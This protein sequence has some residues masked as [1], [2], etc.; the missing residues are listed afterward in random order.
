MTLPEQIEPHQDFVR[1]AARH[2]GIVPT[3]HRA[4][5]DIVLHRKRRERPHQLEGAADAAAA[6]LVGRKAVDAFAGEGNRSSVGR[7]GPGNDVEQR[8]LARSVRADHRKDR[9]L[10]DAKAHVV[11]REQPTKALANSINREKRRHDRRPFT[12]SLAASHGHTPP[13]SAITTASKQSP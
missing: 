4:D 10:G 12:P 8:G 1:A 5:D 7:E 11:D 6:D 3:Q 9:A 13:G 2:G